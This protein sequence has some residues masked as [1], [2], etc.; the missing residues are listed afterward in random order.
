MRL[1]HNIIC[2]AVLTLAVS[3]QAA[4]PALGYNRD[5][6]PILSDNCF[7]CHG[8]DKGNRKAKLRLDV[9]EDAIAK[10]AFVPGKPEESEL[11][12]RLFTTNEDDVMPPADSL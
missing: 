10:E 1:R 12:K 9:R 3:T 8:P 4:A 2:A 11:V 6:R 7:A 5:V